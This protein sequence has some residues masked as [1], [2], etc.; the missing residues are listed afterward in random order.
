MKEKMNMHKAMAMGKKP[1]CGAKPAMKCGGKVKPAM[2]CG[3]DVKKGK[4]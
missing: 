2:K 4:K 1:D 3:G